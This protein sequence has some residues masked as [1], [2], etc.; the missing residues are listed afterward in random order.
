MQHP[1]VVLPAYS[2]DQKVTNISQ[3][4]LLQNSVAPS[5][6]CW[7]T[8]T[9][10]SEVFSPFALASLIQLICKWA[11]QGQTDRRWQMHGARLQRSPVGAMLL[12]TLASAL[13][14]PSMQGLAWLSGGCVPRG[15]L[16]PKG[17]WCAGLFQLFPAA[18][19]SVFH[20]GKCQ[21]C[22]R[23]LMWLL[24]ETHLAISDRNIS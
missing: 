2:G 17:G 5:V 4:P 15:L 16:Y 23:P 19:K 8:V 7:S 3:Q 18:G 13:E 20:T 1:Q 14:I 24:S 21:K 22:W 6:L 12:E 10:P 11:P 9:P